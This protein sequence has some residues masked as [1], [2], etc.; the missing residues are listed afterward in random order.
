MRSQ[1]T[2]YDRHIP[3]DDLPFVDV[4]SLGPSESISAFIHL[5]TSTASQRQRDTNHAKSGPSEKPLHG[6]FFGF[7]QVA[8]ACTQ[9]NRHSVSLSVNTLPLVC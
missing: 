1:A 6:H 9:Q 4:A 5:S 3:F 8:Y 7:L 2:Y